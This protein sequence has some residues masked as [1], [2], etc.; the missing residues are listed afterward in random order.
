MPSTA[1]DPDGKGLSP[2]KSLSTKKTL[3]AQKTMKK[4]DSKDFSKQKTLNQQKTL[5]VDAK[6]DDPKAEVKLSGE[7]Q[8]VKDQFEE[9]L[10][11]KMTTFKESVETAK[12]TGVSP[13]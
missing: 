4:Q 13:D 7:Q 3:A 1:D 10:T 12:T 9:V 2:Q 8:K 11:Q 6:K 5:N